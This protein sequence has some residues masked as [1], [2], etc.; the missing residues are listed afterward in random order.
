M[1]RPPAFRLSRP[2]GTEMSGPIP[3]DSARPKQSEASTPR[4]PAKRRT[5][6]KLAAL[7]TLALLDVGALSSCGQKLLSPLAG[8][9][10]VI[11][12]GLDG[13]DSGIVSSMMAEGSLPHMSRLRELGGFRALTSTVPP[14]SPV[15]WATFITGQDP[16][17]H[18]IHDF[19]HRDPETYELLP[20]IVRTS[21]PEWTIPVGPWQVPLT[22]SKVQLQRR[23]R[24]FWD[25]LGE[26]GIPCQIYRI[27]SNFPPQ[28]TGAKQL[29][30]L[31]TPDFRGTNGVYSYY[32]DGPVPS[33]EAAREGRVQRVAVSGGRTRAR[34]TGP[35]N[36]LHRDRPTLAVDFEVLVDRG[37]RVAKLVIQG[38]EILLR[39]REWSGWVPVRFVLVPGTHSR[40][41]ICRFYLQEVSPHL[42]LYVTPLNFDP[43]DPALPIDAPHGF[44]RQLAERL[45]R[46]HT[47]GL[48]EDTKALAEGVLDDDEYLQQSASVM[49]EA[50]RMYESALNEFERGLLFYYFGT[51]DRNQHIFWRAWDPTHPAHDPAL[52]ADCAAAFEDCYRVSD[53][54]VGRAL[55][56]A[57]SHTTLIVLSDHGFAPYYRRF[58]LNTW[59][60]ENGYL[61]PARFRREGPKLGFSV[62]W[63]QTT[64]YGVGLN[65]LYLNLKGREGQGTVAPEDR[66][67]VARRLADQLLGARDPETGARIVK[68]VYFS[69]EIYSALMP[70]RAPDLIVGYARGYRCSSSSAG[71]SLAEATVEE[72]RDKWSGDHCIDRSVVPGILLATRP[73][74]ASHPALPDVTAS[75]LAEFGLP[76]SDDMCGKPIW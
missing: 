66:R 43:M 36:T 13:L 34:L 6:K 14:Q 28:D 49:D 32:T 50:R 15:A 30:G 68:N 63:D 17:Q 75:V 7:G 1:R 31:G 16:G 42:K 51:S 35:P 73:M 56:A 69:D 70:D 59:L 5:L 44:A 22:S 18:G 26:R 67:A 11:I 29:S 54:L 8:E 76:A 61:L 2:V 25:I 4:D 24:A 12:L 33:D 62:R 23:G 20:S 45:G 74:R 9:R 47:M 39:E 3:D 71:G 41:C 27:P 48:P 65:G 60:A 57:D 58:H 64:A 37:H 19:V 72:N 53:E 10:K 52:S 40:G 55:E 38:Q 46:F 21:P